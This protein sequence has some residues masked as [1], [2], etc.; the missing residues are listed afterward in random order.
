MLRAKFEIWKFRYLF[1]LGFI[2]GA[3][4]VFSNWEKT[5][6]ML[7]PDALIIQATT[8]CVG[9]GLVLVG[10][11]ALRNYFARRTLARRI[12]REKLIAP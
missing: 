6:A 10:L 4:S 11:G 7:P 3:A 9:T 5:Y 2:I 8:L 12:G 1:A